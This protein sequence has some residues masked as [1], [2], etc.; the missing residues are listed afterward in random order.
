MTHHVF[1]GIQLVDVTGVS[2]HPLLQRCVDAWVRFTVASNRWQSMF[3]PYGLDNAVP[4]LRGATQKDILPTFKG[5]SND[6]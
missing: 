4:A 1:Q 6:R 5:D 3:S 2:L